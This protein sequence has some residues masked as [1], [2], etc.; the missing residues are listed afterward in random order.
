MSKYLQPVLTPFVITH[1]SNV[2][3][4]WS[5]EIAVLT[6]FVITHLSNIDLINHI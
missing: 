5:K 6:P 4:L 1:L 2:T 3:D